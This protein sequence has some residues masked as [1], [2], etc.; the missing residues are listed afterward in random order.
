MTTFLRCMAKSLLTAAMFRPGFA[1][2]LK[3]I[4]EL[5]TFHSF[6]S[7][8]LVSTRYSFSPNQVKAV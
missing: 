6:H 4:K 2:Y 3:Q 1:F 7:P 5:S 8:L